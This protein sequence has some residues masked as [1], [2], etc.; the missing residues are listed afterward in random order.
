MH[1]NY[2]KVLSTGK[3]I[4]V[5]LEGKFIQQKFLLGKIVGCFEQRKF[6]LSVIFFPWNLVKCFTLKMNFYPMIPSGYLS[7]IKDF[8]FYFLKFFSAGALHWVTPFEVST[9]YCEIF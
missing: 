9:G 7:G 2:I 6:S 1:H 5:H 3:D 4:L 8:I